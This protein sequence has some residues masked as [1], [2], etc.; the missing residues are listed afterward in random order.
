MNEDKP[1]LTSSQIAMVS[2]LSTGKV[3]LA[4]GT[5]NRAK[6]KQL[7]GLESPLAG[8]TERVFAQHHPRTTAVVRRVNDDTWFDRTDSD[9]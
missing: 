8:N 1:N 7:G 9:L 6:I 2:L 3:L 4:A 5:H